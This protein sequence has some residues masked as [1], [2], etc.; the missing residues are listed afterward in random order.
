MTAKRDEQADGEDGCCAERPGRHSD[1]GNLYLFIFPN[2]GERWIMLYRF[3]GKRREMGLGSAATDH[4]AVTLKEARERA[5]A[6][7]VL[8]RQGVAPSCGLRRP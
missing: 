8:L 5:A 3:G 4:E 2:G 6:A 7:R 1:G